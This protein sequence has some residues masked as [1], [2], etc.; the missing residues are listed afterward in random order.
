MSM[1]TNDRMVLTLRHFG[2]LSY[3]EIAQV[4][5]LDEKDGE[6]EA[7]RSP[8]AA[9]RPPEGPAGRLR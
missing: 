6:I 1:T 9:A 5:D 2:E 7:V 4:L 8:A 3:E